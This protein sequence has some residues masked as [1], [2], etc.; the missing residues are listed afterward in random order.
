MNDGFLRENG[1]PAKNAFLIFTEKHG[2][3][4]LL[5]FQPALALAKKLQFLFVFRILYLLDV[6][7][8]AL[9]ALLDDAKIR[10]DQLQFKICDIPFGIDWTLGMRNGLVLEHPHDVDKCIDAF[11]VTQWSRVLAVTLHEPGDINIFDSGM[12]QLLGIEKRGKLI[13]PWV[14]NCGDAEM[15]F[16]LAAGEFPGIDVSLSQNLEKRGLSDRGKPYNP[17]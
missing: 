17:S 8:E 3:E 2:P 15:R 12:G 5:R 16:G 9:H 1:D 6:F 10:Q 4:R 11:E 14:G 13:Q 7:G